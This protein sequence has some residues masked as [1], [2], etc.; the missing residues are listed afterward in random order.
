V[1]EGQSAR[2]GAA[3]PAGVAARPR[4]G[5]PR[6][7]PSRH[8]P[9]NADASTAARSRLRVV[10]SA[11]ERRRS[12]AAASSRRSLLLL[13]IPT[14]ILLVLGL[15]MVLSAGS[16]SAVEG[17]GTSFWYFQRQSIY[18]VAGGLAL[19][20]AWRLP[21]TV[22]QKL[23]LPMVLAVLP[24]MLIA[25]HPT[26]GT[27]FYG[28]SRWIDLGPVTLQPS[29]FM[30]LAI[31]AFTATILT[32]KWRYLDEPAHLLVPLAP[33]VLLVAAIVILQKDLGTTMIICGTVFLMMFAAGV[34]LKYLTA[35]AAV[36]AMGAALL[37]FGESYRRTRFL[38]AWLNP[39][40]DKMGAGYQLIQGLIALGSGG[41][42]GVG[43]GNSAQKWDYLPNAHSDFIFAIIGE[44]LGLVGAIL[45]LIAFG[46]LLYAG[47]RIAV[48]APDTFG[49]L[50]AAGITCW[51]GVQVIIN[52]GAV[53]GLLPITGVPLPL[54]SFG[55]TALVVTLAGI[56]MLASVARVSGRPAKGSG[57][58]P[59]AGRGSA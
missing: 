21:Y 41:W 19:A 35:T 1:A 2:R 4:A 47:I 59:H 55:G 8:R 32:K 53:T 15:T 43:L 18:A 49:R 17:Y 16:I 38:D 26:S 42:L 51:I 31:V 56:G 27:A 50:L 36:G 5:T 48:R 25:L 30:K 45:T 52:L 12:E 34:R 9:A 39:M 54:V 23:A 20:A 24:L 44:E 11:E 3:R 29:E 6:K 7:A 14:A 22:W 10:P 46:A 28:A 13:L 40:A 37:I 33:V 58:L 57:R